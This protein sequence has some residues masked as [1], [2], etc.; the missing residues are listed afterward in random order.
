[1][2]YSPRISSG[3]AL[4]VLAVV[5]VAAPA[6]A[7]SPATDSQT[8]Q[9]LLSEV[10]QLRQELKAAITSAERAHIMIYRLQLQEAAIARDQQRL[11]DARAKLEQTQSNRKSFAGE[12]KRTEDRLAAATNPAAQ[13]DAQDNLARFKA[14]INDVLLPE[15]QDRQSRAIDCEQQLRVDQDKLRELQE[16]LEQLDTSLKNPG[17]K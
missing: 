3:F 1:M 5:L 16:Q 6:H 12:I 8:L 10:R 15:E 14:H 7:Q 9:A 4:P 17:V 11:D 2:S 13:K